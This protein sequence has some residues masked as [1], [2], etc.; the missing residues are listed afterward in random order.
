M[1]I[2][3]D[4]PTFIDV[5]INAAMQVTDMNDIQRAIIPSPE[6]RKGVPS[7]PSR[8]ENCG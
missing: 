3:L 2:R 5:R 7:T 4:M 1:A 6:N 8:G